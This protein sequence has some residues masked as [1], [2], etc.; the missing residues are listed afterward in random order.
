MISRD[1]AVRGE[2]GFEVAIVAQ[3][4]RIAPHIVKVRRSPLCLCPYIHHWLLDIAIPFVEQLVMPDQYYHIPLGH[5]RRIRVLHL[6]PAEDREAPI[7]CQL[8]T[9]S[10]DD[11]PE[12]D[13]D[14]T[15]LSYAWLV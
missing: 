7:Q 3:H 6:A 1:L 5:P 13:G 4:I 12:W 15:A 8:E 11:H 10:L 9:I 14:Y 2:S